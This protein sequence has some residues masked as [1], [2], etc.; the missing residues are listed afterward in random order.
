MNENLSYWSPTRQ[1]Y[2]V[3]WW[4]LQPDFPNI[5]IPM[6]MD[7]PDLDLFQIHRIP[8][9]EVPEGFILEWLLVPKLGED[10]KYY[11][12]YKFNPIETEV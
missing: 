3:S 4:A 12:D 11:Q 7:V 2:W 9:P 6:Y 5:S 1:K 8:Y 10:G